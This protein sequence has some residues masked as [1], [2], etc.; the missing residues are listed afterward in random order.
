[1]LGLRPLGSSVWR[2]VSS[3]SS[4]HPQDVLL[5]Q[6]ILHVH[7]SGLKPDSFHFI[8]FI[9]ALGKKICL[10]PVTRPTD[11]IKNG[12]VYAEFVYVAFLHK[13]NNVHHLIGCSKKKQKKI[14]PTYPISKKS[15]TG[16]IQLIFLGLITI[17]F[18]AEKEQFKSIL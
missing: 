8:S 4:H 5:V 7:K 18:S 6:F 10:F 9:L 14:R 12:T 1:M 17:I 16:N 3:D 13:N 11:S 2:A 15:V